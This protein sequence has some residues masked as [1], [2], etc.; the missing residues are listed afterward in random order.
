MQER[1]WA[2]VR[3]DLG[4][5]AI[6]IRDLSQ[7]SVELAEHLQQASDVNA[8][9]FRALTHVQAQPGITAGELAARLDRSPA[10]TSTVLDRLEQAGHV[11][12]RPDPDDRRRTTLWVTDLPQRVASETLRPFLTTL[13]EE[14]ADEDPEELARTIAHVERITA[15]LRD[16]LDQQHG[17]HDA[18]G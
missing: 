10:A 8:T 7:A 11:E 6:A 9:D 12:R 17:T 1:P 4:A 14:F 2:Q 5:L 3:P 18:D 15:V 13:F 16:H